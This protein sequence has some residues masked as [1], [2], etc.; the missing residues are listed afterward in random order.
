MLHGRWC[1][2]HHLSNIKKQGDNRVKKDRRRASKNSRVADVS[3]NFIN[4]NGNLG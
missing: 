2:R 4:M 1:S 3:N